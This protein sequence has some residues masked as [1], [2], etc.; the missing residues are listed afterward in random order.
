M[1]RTDLSNPSDDA[2]VS[3]N[4]SFC[5]LVSQSPSSD[6]ADMGSVEARMETTQPSKHDGSLGSNP[7]VTKFVFYFVCVV[8][9]SECCYRDLSN[10]QADTFYRCC[11]ATRIR[12]TRLVLRVIA[13]IPSM[14]LT[15]FVTSA[16]SLSSGVITTQRE[17]GSQKRTRLDR[18]I[19]PESTHRREHQ[20]KP[21]EEDSYSESE[22]ESEEPVRFVLTSEMR[23]S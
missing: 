11:N 19:S 22:S 6:P 18:R 2:S 14:N 17:P 20:S 13:N 21:H 10:Q 12:R 3:Y 23:I 1:S 16:S 7:L 15:P 4:S 9:K 5:A 8:G